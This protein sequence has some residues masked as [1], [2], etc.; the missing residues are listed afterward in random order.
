MF[1]S[2]LNKLVQQA[3]RPL[4]IGLTGGIGSGKSTV[5]QVFAVLG[6]PVFNADAAAKHLMNSDAAIRQQLTELFGEATYGN[7]LLNTRYLA[8]KVFTDSYGLQR[9]NAVVHPVT[10]AAA[11]RWFAAQQS[12]YAVKEAALLFE[13][14]TAAGLDIIAGVYAPEHLRLHRAI[15]RD[16][17]TRDQVLQRM[18][19]QMD[20]KIKMKL[21]DI[22][23]VNDEQQ[24]LV[25][26]VVDFHN[27]LLQLLRERET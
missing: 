17:A 10:I 15:Q 21:C 5:A 12:P 19:R 11:E 27:G 22:I 13:A 7:G 9:L 4:R 14:G 18:H 16:G 23:F 6:I 1:H 20:E 2:G 8:E 24:L 3:H 25:P 26:Q